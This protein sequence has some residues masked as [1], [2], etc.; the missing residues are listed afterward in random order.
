ML[1][2]SV[3]ANL[4]QKPQRTAPGTGISLLWCSMRGLVQLKVIS[5]DFV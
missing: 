5:S 4:F 1:G 2:P 3:T